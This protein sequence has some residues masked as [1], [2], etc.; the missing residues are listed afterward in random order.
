MCMNHVGLSALHAAQEQ[1]TR[2]AE[3]LKGVP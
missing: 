2:F 3:N 1:Q